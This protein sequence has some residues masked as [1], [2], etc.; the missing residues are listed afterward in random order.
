MNIPEPSQPHNM[1][2]RKTT[3]PDMPNVQNYEFCGVNSGGGGFYLKGTTIRWD[4]V[5]DKVIE[6]LLNQDSELWSRYFQK[7]KTAKK[8]DDKSD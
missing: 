1:A 6:H 7:K 2:K 5:S 4:T 3:Q 8:Q